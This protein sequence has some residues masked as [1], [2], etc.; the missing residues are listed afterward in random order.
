MIL[1]KTYEDTFKT[2]F[3]DRDI[4]S[5][6]HALRAEDANIGACAVQAMEKLGVKTKLST[7]RRLKSLL[8]YA[9]KNVLIIVRW[10]GGP[11]C[12]AVVYDAETKKFLDPSGPLTDRDIKCYQRNLDS[13]YFV[14]QKAA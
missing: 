14:E 11:M 5:G 13:M 9:R 7:Y 1:G 10:G 2:L 8:R 12:H 4:Q 3:P 6:D